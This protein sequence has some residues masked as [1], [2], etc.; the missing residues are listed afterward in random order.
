L[1]A[2]RRLHWAASRGLRWIGGVHLFFE[3]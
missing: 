2:S 3:I 1:T